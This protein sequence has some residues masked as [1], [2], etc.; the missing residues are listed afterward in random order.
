MTD[1]SHSDRNILSRSQ[2]L[3]FIFGEATNS[4]FWSSDAFSDDD[5]LWSQLEPREAQFVPME[6]TPLEFDFL[7]DMNIKTLLQEY[8][9]STPTGSP[10]KKART[11]IE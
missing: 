4:G 11:Q 3:K 9:T 1:V 10:M 6:I 7:E 8:R 2:E 5:P